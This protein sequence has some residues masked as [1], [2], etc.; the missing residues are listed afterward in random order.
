MQRMG[1][2]MKKSLKVTKIIFTN[3]VMNEMWL[4]NPWKSPAECGLNTSALD[5]G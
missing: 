4:W 2:E 5:R 1:K 3:F